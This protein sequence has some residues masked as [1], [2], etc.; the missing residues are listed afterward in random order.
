MMAKLKLIT[1]DDILPLWP[2]RKSIN[3]LHVGQPERIPSF[4]CQAENDMNLHR[5]LEQNIIV[6]NLLTS[7]LCFQ[8]G[9]HFYLPSKLPE[10]YFNSFY[11]LLSISRMA[12]DGKNQ[13]LMYATPSCYTLFV[14]FDDLRDRRIHPLFTKSCKTYATLGKANIDYNR[15]QLLENMDVQKIDCS[16]PLIRFVYDLP[17]GTPVDISV[18]LPIEKALENVTIKQLSALCDPVV[19]VT[20]KCNGVDCVTGFLS[21]RK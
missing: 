1:L 15:Y 12:D 2:S 21:E 13:K 5:A 11:R 19:L 4:N 6:Q 10:T 3:D 14:F 16:D 7:F 20:G 9:T 17:S 8:A 18:Y